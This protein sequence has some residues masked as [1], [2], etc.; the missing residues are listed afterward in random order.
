MPRWTFELSPGT[1]AK[2]VTDLYVSYDIPAWFVN[3][4]FH[5]NGEGNFYSAGKTPPQ[6]V[7]LHIDH[8]ARKIASEDIRKDFIAKAND[9]LR[10]V[11]DPRGI[12]WEYNVY[13]HPRDNWRING[14][15]PPVEHPEVYRLWKEKGAPVPYDG[16]YL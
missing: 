7:F 3:V 14:M 5:E 13:E 12:K 1:I 15:I 6:A 16:A 4:F 9:I 2:K 8:A 11:L 10:P